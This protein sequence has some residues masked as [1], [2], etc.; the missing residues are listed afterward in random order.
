[1]I[2][3]FAFEMSMPFSIIVVLN[4]TS[5][6]PLMKPIMIGSNSFSVI[7]PCPTPMRAVGTNFRSFSATCPID[8]TRL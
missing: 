5:I 3:V 2:K 8:S 6:S 1:M 4:R 7:W